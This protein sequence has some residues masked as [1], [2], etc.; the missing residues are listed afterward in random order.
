MVNSKRILCVILAA[1]VMFGTMGIMTAFADNTSSE[2]TLATNAHL[3]ESETLT[4]EP[5]YL[6]DF[7]SELDTKFLSCTEMSALLG[8]DPFENGAAYADDN[9]EGNDL[10][11]VTKTYNSNKSLTLSKDK[12][13]L[14]ANLEIK[15]TDQ[16]RA[17]YLKA[18]DKKF[19]ASFY[20]SNCKDP[21]K[22][23]FSN[24][25]IRVYVRFKTP[26]K[27]YDE[28]GKQKDK[29]V[30]LKLTDLTNESSGYNCY[31]QFVDKGFSFVKYGSRY[32]EEEKKYEDYDIPL[33]NLDDV[34][35]IIISLYHYA[36]R[37]SEPT[38]NKKTLPT[39]KAYEA[40]LEM[41][42]FAYDGK[43]Q[44][45][46][47]K[48]P[49]AL[50]NTENVTFTDWESYYLKSFADTPSTVKY[51][52]EDGKYNSKDYKTNK[53]GWAYLKETNTVTSKQL[54]IYSDF[55]R[56]Q[57]NKAV[58]TANQEGGT[59]KAKLTVYC[60][61]ILD[62]KNESMAVEFQITFFKYGGETYIPIQEYIEPGKVK[63]FSFDVS[64]LDVNS[65][66]YVRIAFMAFWKY[67]SETKKFYDTD[68]MKRYDKKGNLLKAIRDEK[69]GDLLGYSADE[70]KTFVE[71]KDVSKFLAK[72]SD[73]R[74]DVD[75]TKMVKNN[76]LSMKTIENFEGFVSP[77]YTVKSGESFG[78]QTVATTAAGT[79]GNKDYEYAGYHFFDFKQEA[80]N[81]YYGLYTHPS[82]INFL[83]SK[84]Y[85]Q[86]NIVDKN[87]KTDGQ[88]QGFKDN[89]EKGVEIANNA[90][91]NKLYQ[92]AA[93]L[94]SGG[95]QIEIKSPYPRVQCQHQTSFFLSGASEDKERV[96]NNQ[97]HKPLKAQG[98]K[99]NYYNQMKAGLEY[100]QNHTNPEKRDYLAID[101]YVL[102]SVHGYKNVYNTT[103]KNW[104]KKNKKTATN[105]NTRVQVQ[106]TINAYNEELGDKAS[107]S[108]AK[109][110][111]VGEKTT[112]Y[113]D[114]SEL[115]MNEIKSVTLQPQSY[116]NLSNKEQGGDD[117][118]VGITDLRVRFSAIY[119]PSSFDKGLTTTQN[120]TEPLK[121][122]DAKKIKKLFDAL[123]GLKASDYT[124]YEDYDKLYA[125]IKAWTDASLSTQEYCTKTWGIDYSELSMLEAEVYENLFGAGAGD[126]FPM[127]DIAFPMLAVI[128]LGISGY[129]VVRTRKSKVK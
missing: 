42:G 48:A 100:A 128:V 60:P 24:A 101:V 36:G 43:P 120:V 51:N 55:D 81:G 111:N 74:K 40:T 82:F 121:L 63:T 107:A 49:A 12:T 108:V 102:S 68:T 92:E 14:G 89:N 53:A 7:D 21:V 122:S 29:D 72:C 39:E 77:I 62:T 87:L 106:V 118:L 76:T 112:L 8:Q 17:N 99:Y 115:N 117:K 83:S 94:A 80:L 22:K 4:G 71:D 114:V 47:F 75:I 16:M 56:D 119:V 30:Y 57:F 85:L 13:Q 129:L 5:K 110:V 52:A 70:G 90:E 93:G 2:K 28:T 50:A 18:V 66:N 69:T 25:M 44:V 61:K 37:N 67:D 3:G 27:M 41:S 79:T 109:F 23:K 91:Y 54:N 88:A 32:N 26:Y 84:S 20:L 73:G 113:I 65:V 11:G 33:D 15:V 78:D 64:E 127:G 125:L 58:V 10:S 126:L 97:N 105:V 45:N 96:E 123:P 124:T 95:Y 116:E 19:Y 1:L 34:Q 86:N 31:Q 103:Y 46:E 6:F 38:D 98:E 9:F 35:S 104:C 59:K